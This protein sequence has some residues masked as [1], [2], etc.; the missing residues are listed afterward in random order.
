LEAQHT[1]ER[2]IRQLE[3][4]ISEDA[5][6]DLENAENTIQ[7]LRERSRTFS[8]ISLGKRDRS[9]DGSQNQFDAEGRVCFL[10]LL[11]KFL[12]LLFN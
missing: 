7:M 9:R 2:A 3:E 4:F 12:S 10:L 1:A 5:K 8:N 6:L 11:L